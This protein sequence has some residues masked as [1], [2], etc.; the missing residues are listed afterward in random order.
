[1]AMPVEVALA[2]AK[3]SRFANYGGSTAPGRRTKGG[4]YL[5]GGG[6]M[7]VVIRRIGFVLWFLIDFRNRISGKGKRQNCKVF[8]PMFFA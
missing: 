1:M 5:A 6:F 2:V 4:F 3:T 8:F 7:V